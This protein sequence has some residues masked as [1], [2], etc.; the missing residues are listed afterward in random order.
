MLKKILEV[1]EKFKKDIH[2]DIYSII[3]NS[4][5]RILGAI[6][7]VNKTLNNEE[8]VHRMEETLSKTVQKQ[9]RIIEQL[10]TN[11]YETDRK[12]NGLEVVVFVPYR[13]TPVVFKDG[14]KVNT[15]HMTS[16]DV[17][18]AYD[19]KTEVTVRSE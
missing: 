16:L 11:E 2:K 4:E 7:A 1:I 14:K 8:R 15:G 13:G 10:L 19:R 5:N 9:D 17:N 6:N 3:F 12:N 18:W